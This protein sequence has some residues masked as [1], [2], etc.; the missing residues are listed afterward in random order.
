MTACFVIEK[1]TAALMADLLLWIKMLGGVKEHSAVLCADPDLD[2]LEVLPALNHA[3]EAFKETAI[4]L[5]QNFPADAAVLRPEIIPLKPSWLD[6]WP[7]PKTLVVDK[8]NTANTFARHRTS[9]SHHNLL[10]LEDVSDQALLFLGNRDGTLVKVLRHARFPFHPENEPRMFL[11]TGCNGDFIFMMPALREIYRRTGKKPIVMVSESYEPVFEGVSYAQAMAI[12]RPNN[13]RNVPIYYE[14]YRKLYPYLVISQCADP[15]RVAHFQV[16][17][18]A[19]NYQQS[20]WQRM[21]LLELMETLPLEFDR[22][23]PVREERLRQQHFR[24]ARPKLLYNFKGVSS[25]CKTCGKVWEL[26][27]NYRH[28]FELVDLAPLKAYRIYDILG[29]MD[30]A[31]GL[32]TI[33]TYSLHLAHGSRIPYVAL[34][35]DKRDG[36]ESTPLGNVVARMRYDEIPKR[37]GEIQ[38]AVESWI[39]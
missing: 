39:N 26:L 1:K 19:T 7:V 9:M 33:D 28:K 38:K 24:T 37:L 11:Q 6:Q 4:W 5:H 18:P 35:R 27:Q 16:K 23:D 12:P 2:T 10:T 17:P 31:A 22:R 32:I 30:H 25:P 8:T 36:G 34:L 29:L 3:A 21:G 14:D 15:S 13:F 20:I